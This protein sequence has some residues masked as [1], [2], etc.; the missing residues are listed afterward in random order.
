MTC[1]DK[2]DREIV[3]AAEAVKRELVGNGLE[4]HIDIYYLSAD[5]AIAL[6]KAVQA[7]R[8]AQR[9]PCNETVEIPSVFC[10]R[11]AVQELNDHGGT[12]HRCDE[13]RIEVR[14]L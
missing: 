14:E 8:D 3:A 12:F 13:H 2:Y 7:K 10:G 11:P 5:T 9:P 4:D 1:D 6:V